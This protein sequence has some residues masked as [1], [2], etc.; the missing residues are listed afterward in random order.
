MVAT[1]FSAVHGPAAQAMSASQPS[2]R[3]AALSHNFAPVGASVS[4]R[5]SGPAPRA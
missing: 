1:F 2:V 4:A 3:K 5:P